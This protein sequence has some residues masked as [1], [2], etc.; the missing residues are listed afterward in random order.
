MRRIVWQAVL[1]D[2]LMN[3]F[4]QQVFVA[5]VKH[6]RVSS[7]LPCNQTQCYHDKSSPSVSG[8]L[9]LHHT[10]R[11]LNHPRLRFRTSTLSNMPGLQG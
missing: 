7:S 5:V 8:P 10:L 2:A 9:P 4:L 3:G 11:V 6:S 1:D